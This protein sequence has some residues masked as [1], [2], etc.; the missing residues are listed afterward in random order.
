VCVVA[1]S[2]GEAVM[3]ERAKRLSTSLS[4]S[5]GSW[6]EGPGESVTYM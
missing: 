4:V 1:G 3:Y 6:H 5:C 2:H